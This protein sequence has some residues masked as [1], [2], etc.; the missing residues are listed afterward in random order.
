MVTLWSQLIR[1][2]N[3]DILDPS[4]EV[5]QTPLGSRKT[6]L[7]TYQQRHMEQVQK[8][9]QRPAASTES[10]TQED[11]I[12]DV[13]ACPDKRY[14]KDYP[15]QSLSYFDTKDVAWIRCPFLT[16]GEVKDV[17][18]ALPHFWSGSDHTAEEGPTQPRVNPAYTGL[19]IYPETYLSELHQD[20]NEEKQS[21]VD[22]EYTRRQ[23]L[24]DDRYER[25]AV[26]FTGVPSLGR[27]EGE[28]KDAWSL[29]VTQQ[30]AAHCARKDAYRDFI[31][32]I[33]EQQGEIRQS[34]G[35][36]PIRR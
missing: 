35:L 19:V 28:D 8:D 34:L 18:D 7:F 32:E 23:I 17:L 29:R 10:L 2:V 4:S 30:R 36:T 27:Q 3:P 22:S 6:D 13:G 11:P 20:W 21:Y 1:H 33:A 12:A 16:L 9:L 31:C 5:K 15:Y 14:R 26:R 24:F 25:H